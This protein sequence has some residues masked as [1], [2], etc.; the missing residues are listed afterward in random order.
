[1]K[2]TILAV[3]VLGVAALA[4]TQATAKWEVLAS[5]GGTSRNETVHLAWTLGET[6]T[7]ANDNGA[8]ILTEGFQ[9]PDFQITIVAQT[10]P[11]PAGTTR[12]FPNPTT[13]VLQ[14]FIGESGN[15]TYRIALLD[16]TGLLLTE[17]RIQSPATQ[18]MDLTLY[19]A[20]VYL[21]RIQSANG[22]HNEVFQVI[23]QH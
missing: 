7:S 3:L 11:A 9:Q 20:G 19:P 10:N 21:L 14:I 2:K 16:H 5:Q 17:Q 6:A 18:E 15:P 4:N 12:V 23:N 13:G 8:V 22:L 1:M